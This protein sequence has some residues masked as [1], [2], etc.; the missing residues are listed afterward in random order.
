[1]KSD[2]SS[3]S[4]SVPLFKV[5]VWS[6]KLHKN[7]G[8][9]K[10][11]ALIKLGCESQ[12]DVNLPTPNQAGPSQ[13]DTWF[14]SLNCRVEN[15]SQVNMIS[16]WRKGSRRLN[17]TERAGLWIHK[18]KQFSEQRHRNCL[19][20]MKVRVDVLV[21]CG[22]QNHR[23]TKVVLPASAGTEVQYWNRVA[24]QQQRTTAHNTTWTF[25]SFK[26][27]TNWKDRTHPFFCIYHRPNQQ[28]RN[29]LRETKVRVDVLVYCFRQN[30]R[31]TNKVVLP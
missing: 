4:G 17:A 3:A 13:L 21:H 26:I 10:L 22:Q 18:T 29:C 12:T 15:L 27:I 9:Y 7:T 31:M 20:A 1:M 5:I 19:R 11:S 24:W 6:C 16:F 30:H 8:N 2:G 23:T 25:S 14:G 28:H